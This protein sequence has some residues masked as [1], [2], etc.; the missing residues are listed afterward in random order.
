MVETKQEITDLS[1][2]SRNEPQVKVVKEDK[3]PNLY[4]F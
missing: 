2:V 3:K 4:S 1:L